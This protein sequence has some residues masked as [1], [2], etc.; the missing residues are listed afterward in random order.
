[1]YPVPYRM[2]SPILT[3]YDQ[4]DAR[5]LSSPL[6]HNLA[7]FKLPLIDGKWISHLATFTIAPAQKDPIHQPV[8]YVDIFARCCNFRTLKFSVQLGREAS[9]FAGP[10]EQDPM[11]TLPFPKFDDR[12]ARMVVGKMFR[13]F[14]DNDPA[15]KLIALSVTFERDLQWDRAQTETIQFPIRICKRESVEKSFFHG[16]CF[17]NDPGKWV[18]GHFWN[19]AEE[20]IAFEACNGLHS[21]GGKKSRLL[22]ATQYRHTSFGANTQAYHPLVSCSWHS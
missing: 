8:E 14:F 12:L 13:S 16:G 2:P 17:F 21:I 6:L 3:I 9:D 22:Q 18:K 1:M 5:A 10:Y 15:A 20:L 7:S 19:Q 4:P 11:G